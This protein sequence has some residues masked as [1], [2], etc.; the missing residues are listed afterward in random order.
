MVSMLLHMAVSVG[1]GVFAC[2]LFNGA[3]GKLVGI[4]SA[5]VFALLA[6]NSQAVVYSV[7]QLTLM[8]TFCYV[9]ALVCYIQARRAKN[10]LNTLLWVALCS[11]LFIAGLLIKQNIVTLPLAI[12]LAELCFFG[13]WSRRL[14]GLYGGICIVFLSLLLWVSEFNLMRS[15]VLLDSTLR[16]ST[17]IA[18][19][20]Y[21]RTQMLVLWDYIAKFF[22]PVALQLEHEF[23]L[24]TAWQTK[25]LVGLAA[26]TAFVLLAWWQRRRLPL[27][28]FGVLFYF[29][30]HLVE[31]S[32]LPIRDLAFEHRT[33]LPN[34]GLTLA[35]VGVLQAICQ[36]FQSRLIFGASF[37]LFG[38]WVAAS[39]LAL[40]KRV[41]LWT[42][43]IAFYKNEVALVKGNP[44]VYANLGAK[45]VEGGHCLEAMGYFTHA[46]SLYEKQHQANI[47]LQPELIQNYIECLR[48]FGIDDKANAYELWLLEQVRAPL[49][50]A[51]ILVQRSVYLMD[52]KAFEDALPL[53]EEAVSLDSKNYPAVMNLAISKANLGQLDSAEQLFQQAIEIKPGDPLAL[54]MLR[55]LQKMP[56]QQNL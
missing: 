22:Y 8:A 34:I 1:V 24:Q 39:A 12:L 27:V 43:P 16:E 40:E 33:Y 35:V 51:Q 7:Q 30:A 19:L 17:D 3:K 26:M 13:S 10:A 5:S 2:S 11:G 53:L 31:S 15:L 18:R 55:Q 46:M 28:S 20:D 6:L 4:S 9:W 32:V 37:I 36:K 21:L 49:R 38:G 41:T 50:R 29:V 45:L 47:G 48:E 42:D 14:I 44:R 25:N 56:S 54:D 23:Q 52:K